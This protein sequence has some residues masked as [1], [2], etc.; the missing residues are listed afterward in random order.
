[1][2]EGNFDA[3]SGIV[4]IWQRLGI[5]NLETTEKLFTY[6]ELSASQFD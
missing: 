2:L 6:T 5:F 1:M 4:L 3:A